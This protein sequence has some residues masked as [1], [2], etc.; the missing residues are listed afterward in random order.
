MNYLADSD[1]IIQKLT[2]KN[3]LLD[4]EIKEYEKENQELEEKLTKEGFSDMRMIE[5]TQK[6]IRNL[7]KNVGSEEND[8]YNGFA[9]KWNRY[10]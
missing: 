10:L 6:S 3:N 8:Y 1:D 4:E 5:Q 9:N 2:K 7:V